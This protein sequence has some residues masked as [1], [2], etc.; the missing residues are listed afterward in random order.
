MHAVKRIDELRAADRELDADV[1]QLSRM[2]D[3]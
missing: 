2:L 3:G 1:T